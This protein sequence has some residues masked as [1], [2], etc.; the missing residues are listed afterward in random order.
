MENYLLSLKSAVACGLSFSCS[1]WVTDTIFI[2]LCGWGLYFLL[3]ACLQ[4]TPS[5]P[6]PRRDRNSRKHQ[7]ELKVRNRSRKKHGAL[8]ACQDFL[9]ELEEARRL[10][11]LLQR[12]L[13]MH[14]EK[15]SCHQPLG[16]DPPGKVWQEVP[17][18][19][20]N[21]SPWNCVEDATPAVSLS[22][23]P[24]NHSLPLASTH[25]PGPM[26][27]SISDSSESYLT[28]SEPSDIPLPL[29][30]LCPQPPAPSPQRPSVPPGSEAWPPT[31][32]ASAGSPSPGS[33]VTLPQCES[34]SLPTGTAPHSSPHARWPP[35]PVRTITGLGRSTRPHFHLSWWDSRAAKAVRLSD[36]PHPESL[37]GCLHSP[38][39][40]VPFWRDTRNHQVGDRKPTF[41]SSDL[42][43]LLEVLFRERVKLEIGKERE[44]AEG[45][46][47]HLN[48]LGNML[49]SLHDTGN[50]MGGPPL[51]SMKDQL[52]GARNPTH[53][54]IWG[55][56]LQKGGQLPSSLHNL[57]SESLKAPV[58]VSVSPE[59][60]PSVLLGQL[61][62]FF[63]VPIQGAGEASYHPLSQPSVQSPVV[64][65]QYLIP[66]GNQ[67]WA[68]PQAQ[69]KTQAH[70]TTSCSIPPT[71]RP[72]Q[73]GYRGISSPASPGS[74]P[75]FMPTMIQNLQSH[76][77][78][79]HLESRTSAPMQKTSQEVP[80][81]S[82]VFGASQ[83]PR[84]LP[85]R[86]MR[87]PIPRCPRKYAKNKLR[88]HFARK[89]VQIPEGQVPVDGHRS[90]LGTSH[91]LQLYR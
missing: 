78:Q 65:P 59:E 23:S 53:P 75:S 88:A 42:W 79:K 18:R 2:F 60:P 30:S 22:A 36:S 28:T 19:P 62:N 37:R 10:I 40:G 32:M 91:A 72:A 4:S 38:P 82:Q 51:W 8:K 21:Q 76:L 69:V 50:V 27:S 56:H 44:A 80:I 31:L 26:F 87:R 55:N 39:P 16:H 35:S 86:R 73:S 85:Q 34:V 5:L 17:A 43:K 90:R 20:W 64:Q 25:S 63:P 6:P 33:S 66:S 12:R 14:P 3:L 9:Q 71:S 84:S 41:T 57:H 11:L 67:P 68:A 24:T 70:V 48:S 7:K 13:R 77:S 29:E 52:L 45:S 15:G 47:S 49:K 58:R 1:G 89:F 81:I 83:A 74:M 54:E 61:S 46:E